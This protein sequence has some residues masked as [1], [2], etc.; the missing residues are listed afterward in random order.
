MELRC[1]TTRARRAGNETGL[2]MAGAE[3]AVLIRNP[4]PWIA[5]GIKAPF[6]Y[7]DRIG[8]GIPITKIRWSRDRLIFL[9]GI[10]VLLKQCLLIS[11]CFYVM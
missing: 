7:K 11:D 5:F 2:P 9:M 4:T 6:E 8:I 10:P 1:A 3:W